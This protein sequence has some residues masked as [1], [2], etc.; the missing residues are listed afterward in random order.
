MKGEAPTLDNI[1]NRVKAEAG[2]VEQNLKAQNI[3]QRIGNILSSLSPVLL[4]IF[5]GIA[6]FIGLFVLIILSA[7]LIGLLTG[8]ASFIGHHNT[9]SFLHFPSFLIQHGK[10]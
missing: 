2:K 1:I 5:K 3:G 9:I 4:T 6:M 10:V 8:G 7:V